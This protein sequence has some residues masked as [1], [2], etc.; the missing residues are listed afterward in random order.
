MYQIWSVTHLHWV[1]QEGE[2]PG[3]YPSGSWSDEKVHD[4]CLVFTKLLNGVSHWSRSVSLL[5]WR[6]YGASFSLNMHISNPWGRMPWSESLLLFGRWVQRKFGYLA[7]C[8]KSKYDH[9]VDITTT[10]NDLTA[11]FSLSMGVSIVDLVCMQNVIIII[12]QELWFQDGV[13]SEPALS[14]ER[15]WW[16]CEGDAPTEIQGGGVAREL[17]Y[18]SHDPVQFRWGRIDC[19][20]SW[21]QAW[22][23][24]DIASDI[25]TCTVTLQVDLSWASKVGGDGISMRIFD[26]FGWLEILGKTRNSSTF[27]WWSTSARWW[28]WSTWIG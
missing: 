5:S 6:W 18:S 11:H 23:A 2:H 26:A 13:K 19:P 3:G 4:E 17:C 14:K 7:L 27:A 22:V 21:F 25:A 10:M 20:V 1:E 9:P 8:F 24:S 16:I 28:C 15:D 12:N